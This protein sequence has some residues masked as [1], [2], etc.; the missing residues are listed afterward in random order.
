M[1]IASTHANRNKFLMPEH[2][3]LH[4]LICSN[5]LFY[6]HANSHNGEEAELNLINDYAGGK[7]RS[8]HSNAHNASH[9]N[10]LLEKAIRWSH[11][12]Q[13]RLRMRNAFSELNRNLLR[14]FKLT[15]TENGLWNEN[16]AVTQT[17]KANM[18]IPNLLWFIAF[19]Q[20]IRFQTNQ[21]TA[22]EIRVFV[23]RIWFSLWK[24]A[25]ADELI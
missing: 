5:L 10:V 18:R 16:D 15:A 17:L 2:H 6:V 11:A 21:Y 7:W 12:M 19:N 14:K 23:V 24:P 25:F 9:Y 3:Y 8:L 4:T 1:R 22:N 20:I 13:L